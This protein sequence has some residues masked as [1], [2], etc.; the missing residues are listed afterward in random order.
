MKGAFGSSGAC[1]DV[2]DGPTCEEAAGAQQFVICANMN[3]E[4]KLSIHA[5]VILR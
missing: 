1:L 2:D 3:T 5:D 4:H